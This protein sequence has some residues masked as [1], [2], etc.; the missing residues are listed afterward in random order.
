MPDS[1]ASRFAFE[2]LFLVALA[3]AVVLADLRPLLIAGVMLGGWVIVALLEWAAW[4]GEPHYASG[5]PP[6]YY[7]P[8]VSLPPRRPLEQVARYPSAEQRDEA[9]TWI[10]SAA[11]R[12]EVLG[13]WPVAP[14]TAGEDTQEEEPPERAAEAMAEVAAEPEPEPELEAE[15][16]PVVAAALDDNVGAVDAVGVAD[17]ADDAEA[18]Q[19]PEPALEPEPES[20]GEPEPVV[21]AAL[22][23]AVAGV[24]A[25]GAAGAVELE[26]EAAATA[27]R[28]RWF[29]QRRG[30]PAVKPDEETDAFYALEEVSEVEPAQVEMPSGE[31]EEEAELEGKPEP[32]LEP[33][34]ESGGE[35]EP[36]VAAALAGAVAGVG[37]VGAAGEVELEPEAAATAPRRRW[38]WQR[39]GDPAVK[40]DEETD[41]FYALEEEAELE[42][43][44]EPALEAEPESGGEPE[45]VVAAAL[46]G[47]VAGVGAVGA[48]GAVE[49]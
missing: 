49:L 46:A 39:R 4:R 5:L 28:R 22:A 19:E 40:P 2:V 24:G 44:P 33:E 14:G 29:W 42:G 30:D 11:L 45:P 23:G 41:P 43:K 9:P 26:P 48:A 17:D 20:G 21:A 1:R 7:V 12:A 13:A 10:A 32:A 3:V 25:V 31:L 15:P 37:A 47:A 16:E 18:R 36:V 8:Q 38:F 34:P 27:P 6:R 35:P